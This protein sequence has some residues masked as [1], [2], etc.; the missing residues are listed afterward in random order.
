M[1][2]TLPPR[3]PM[4]S[5]SLVQRFRWV[6]SDTWNVASRDLIHWV[7]QPVRI[8]SSVMYPVVSILIFGYVFGN[9][10]MVASGGWNYREFL[11]PGLF[12]QSVVL[13]VG[14]TLVAIAEDTHRGVNSRFR[15]MPMSSTGFLAGR[16]AADLLN[17][18]LDIAVLMVCG[19]AVGWEWRL[20]FGNVLAAFGLLLLLRF[21]MIWLG[22]FLGLVIKPENTSVVWTIL[23]PLTMFSDTFVSPQTMPHWMGVISE[24]NPLSAT[25]GAIRGLFGNP[26]WGGDSWVAQHSLLMAVVWPLAIT[27]VFWPLAVRRYRSLS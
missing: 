3:T 9:A 19:L 18:T 22:I 2:L 5:R 7:R 12:G 25:V 26:G 23:L 8:F 21:A 11:M 15:S 14:V 27:A 24:W 6:V 20:G 17:S 10:V 4:A 16:S 1:T 13:G